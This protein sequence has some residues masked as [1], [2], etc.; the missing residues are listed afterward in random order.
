MGKTKD[1]HAKLQQFSNSTNKYGKKMSFFC[2]NVCF[3][4]LLH[5]FCL[6]IRVFLLLLQR[7]L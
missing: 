5:D 4:V 2:Q 7:I 1:L 6:R 3:F